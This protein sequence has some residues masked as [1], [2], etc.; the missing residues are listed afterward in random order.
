MVTL[1]QLCAE[2]KID[3]REAGR[4]LGYPPSRMLTTQASQRVGEIAQ[5]LEIV[6]RQRRKRESGTRC[7]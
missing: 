5:G 2:L 7:A 3:P 4:L 1:N 6:F